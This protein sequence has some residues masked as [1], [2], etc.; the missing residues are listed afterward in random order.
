MVRT[1]D[2]PTELCTNYAGGE[3]GGAMSAVAKAGP[4]C[5]PCGGPLKDVVQRTKKSTKVLVH[6]REFGLKIK[7]FNFLS[8]CI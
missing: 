8:L 2:N 3:E 1:R 7:T 4:D 5:D 6:K